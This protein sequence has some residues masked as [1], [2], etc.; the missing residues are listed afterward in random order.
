MDNLIGLFS[1][2]THLNSYR[3]EHQN[4]TL[5]RLFILLFAIQANAAYQPITTVSGTVSVANFPAVQTVS[6]ALTVS[7]TGTVPVSAAALP[8]PSGA[9]TSAKQDTG[10][11]SLSAIDSNIFDLRLG[12]NADGSAPGGYGSL[13]SGY[14]GTNTQYI[15]TNSAGEIIT[16]SSGTTP[17]TI[18]NSLGIASGTITSITNTVGVSA[19]TVAITAASTL[20]V[21][22]GT[23]AVTG[24]LTDAQLRASSV[25]VS[26]GTV[27]I[28][29]ASL[30]TH[31]VTQSGAWSQSVLNSIGIASGT[32]G[33][34][35]SLGIASGT[36]TSITNTVGVSA[37]T[38]TVNQGTSPWVTS[39]TVSQNGLW[40]V[41]VSFTGTVATATVSA[42]TSGGTSLWTFGSNAARKSLEASNDTNA[43]C[44]LK[45]GTG[46]TSATHTAYLVADGGYY[47]FIQP[48][49][50]GTVTVICDA[51]ITSG[52]FMFTEQ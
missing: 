35:N 39:G 31:P 48:V 16:V 37:G 33:I 6:G 23:V 5:F 22:A 20:G 45:K 34:S 47:N 19:G 32:V 36:I 42:T 10:N 29:A 14:D 52:G 38:V 21:S 46:V 24:P 9:A 13:I 51:A 40:S 11:A 15:K 1:Q 43:N 28:T 49:Y 2:E 30:P 17:V 12:I 25:S 27:A 44:W 8:L 3:L 50:T 7:S 26:A 4:M 18:Q 41:G